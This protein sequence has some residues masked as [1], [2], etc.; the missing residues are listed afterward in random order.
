MA[1]SEAV[2]RLRRFARRVADADPDFGE[3]QALR[4]AGLGAIQL[5]M[6]AVERG[7]DDAGI[8]EL[9]P[10]LK[11]PDFDHTFLKINMLCIGGG[12][13]SCIKATVEITIKAKCKSV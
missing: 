10:I 3:A 6:L 2:R 5:A 11:N 12:S 7:A 1:E 8:K 9:E 13:D 4:D